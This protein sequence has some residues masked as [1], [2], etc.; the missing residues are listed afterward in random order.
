MQMYILDGH[1]PV[2]CNDVNT[3]SKWFSAAKRTVESTMVESDVVVST[4]FLGVDHSFGNGEPPL[5]FETMVFGGEENGL[6]ERVDTWDNAVQMHKRIVAKL[7]HRCPYCN[8]KQL[9]DEVQCWAC[10]A[11]L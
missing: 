2:L 1:R 5:L 6:C 3:W 11:P 9:H 10:S 8:A 4:V 7:N